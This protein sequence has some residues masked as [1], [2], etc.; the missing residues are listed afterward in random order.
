MIQT[1]PSAINQPL[2]VVI[3]DDGTNLDIDVKLA[4]DGAGTITST[5]Q[6]VIDVVNDEAGYLV[7]AELTGGLGTATAVAVSATALTGGF[8]LGE[9]VLSGVA[10]TDVDKTSSPN[11]VTLGGG[12]YDLPE[13][14]VLMLEAMTPARLVGVLE[15]QP[16]TTQL[17]D[18]ALAGKTNSVSVA[19]AGS[20]IKDALVGYDDTL[21]RYL[22]G[23]YVSE[24][25]LGAGIAKV[26]HFMVEED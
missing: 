12:P 21:E 17:V 3:S 1:D 7:F 2:N 26:Y 19:I 22:A 24:G 16:V 4:T 18:G 20:A 25:V 13:G 5:V 6:D 10:V 23:G 9:A 14:V 11:T 15:Q 8:L